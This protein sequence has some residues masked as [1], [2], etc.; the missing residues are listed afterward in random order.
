MKR[1][2]FLVIAW[3]L[4]TLQVATATL[5]T[6][7]EAQRAQ[8]REGRSAKQSS[9]V[10]RSGTARSG[11]TSRA[12]TPRRTSPSTPQRSPSRTGAI[13][14]GIADSGSAEC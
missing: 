14:D 6:L 8:A 9:N 7:G 11:S 13:V 4:L 10:K 12:R 2:S 1:N 5:P 3:L